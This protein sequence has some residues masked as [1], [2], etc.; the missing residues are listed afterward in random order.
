MNNKE[1]RELR[2]EEMERVSGGAGNPRRPPVET[3]PGIIYPTGAL[4]EGK[5]KD[6]GSGVPAQG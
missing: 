4:G 6:S 3:G 2:L 1:T 5:R